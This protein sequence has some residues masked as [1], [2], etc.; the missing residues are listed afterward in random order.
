MYTT[1]LSAL[2]YK[3]EQ[4]PIRACNYVKKAEFPPV[5]KLVTHCAAV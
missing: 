1:H 3:Q 4:E 2:V 5:L